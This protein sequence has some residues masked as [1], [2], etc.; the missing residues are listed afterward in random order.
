MKALLIACFLLCLCFGCATTSN[1][2]TDEN[3][4][5][6]SYD[7]SAYP[8]NCMNYLYPW[9]GFYPDCFWYYD[10]YSHYYPYYPSYFY[11]PYYSCEDHR[12]KD[13]F[14]RE[15][16]EQRINNMRQVRQQRIEQRRARI[17]S[18]QS[19]LQRF[20]PRNIMR[21]NPNLFRGR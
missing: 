12:P 20:R 4:Y 17:N 16:F 14:W 5:T 3:L 9:Y 7:C 2:W 19:A 18:I 11:H 10:A 13:N 21:A 6:Y 15:A 8:Y 1:V